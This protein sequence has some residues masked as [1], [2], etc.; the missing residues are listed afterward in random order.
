VKA[1]GPA[2]ESGVVVIQW[3]QGACTTTCNANPSSLCSGVFSNSSIDHFLTFVSNVW[4]FFQ[5][6]ILKCNKTKPL[7]KQCNITQLPPQHQ[8]NEDKIALFKIPN[9]PKFLDYFNSN[10][11]SINLFYWISIRPKT[12]KCEWKFL[13][14]KR[15]SISVA[16]HLK[17]APEAGAHFWMDM[18]WIIH[19]LSLIIS[20]K[21]LR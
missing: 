18:P 20:F 4:P 16:G 12:L 5:N 10:T 11:K 14:R 8:Q 15:I 17:I 13:F 6:L 9:N 2:F 3:R 1:Y 21:N 19:S 7:P